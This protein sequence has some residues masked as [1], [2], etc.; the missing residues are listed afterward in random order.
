MLLIEIVEINVIDD[1]SGAPKVRLVFGLF[2]NL[3]DDYMLLP[4]KSFE[5]ID[6]NVFVLV[7]FP[8]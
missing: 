3:L 7:V 2:L 6:A 1:H 5:M 4:L 8:L